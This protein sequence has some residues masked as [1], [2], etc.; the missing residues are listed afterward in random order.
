MVTARLGRDLEE[1]RGYRVSMAY[2][3]IP[4]LAVFHY[5]LPARPP[6]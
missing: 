6:A 1:F 3:P 2:P 5:P 4:T